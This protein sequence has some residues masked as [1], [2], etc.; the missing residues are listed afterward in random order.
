MRWF[1]LYLV[2]SSG[3]CELSGSGERGD[4]GVTLVAVLDHNCIRL[5]A[6]AATEARPGPD[7]SS[8]Q[9]STGQLTSASSSTSSSS[10]GLRK[11]FRIFH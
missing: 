5:A 2:N 3:V 11:Y 8:L 10:S 1:D 4:T 7:H 6:G 9:L